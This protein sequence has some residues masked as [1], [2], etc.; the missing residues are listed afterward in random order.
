MNAQLPPIDPDIHD[1]LARR[2]GGRLPEGLLAD[3]HAAVAAVPMEAPRVR[4]DRRVWWRM[5]RFTAP[6]AALTLVAALAVGLVVVPALQTGPAASPAGYP[7]NRALTTAELAAVMAGPA[8]PVNTALTAT[9]TIQRKADACPMNSRPTVGVIEGMGSQVCVMGADVSAYLTTDKET[10]TF[11]FRYLG[12]GMLGLLGKVTPASASKVA[13]GAADTWPTTADTILVD[14]W[15]GSYDLPCPLMTFVPGDPLNPNGNCDYSWLAESAQFNTHPQS[16]KPGAT[17]AVAGVAVE[18][19]G[20]RI[21]DGIPASGPPVHGVFVVRHEGNKQCPVSIQESLGDAYCPTWLV[22]AKLANISVPKPAAT[23]TALTGYPADRPLTATEMAAL[24]AG[25]A[26]PSGTAIVASGT[27]QVR[28]DVCPMNRM[29]GIGLL[30]DMGSQVCVMDPGLAHSAYPSQMTGVFAYRY[31]L[32]GYLMFLG[33]VKPADSGLSFGVTDDWP[34]EGQTFVVQGWLGGE[35]LRCKSTPAPGIMEVLLKTP[36]DPCS[37][38]WLSADGTGP[39]YPSGPVQTGQGQGGALPSATPAPS[40]YASP[41]D[42]FN[43][44]GRARLVEADGA[45][46]LDNLPKGSTPIHGAFVVRS[47]V[48]PCPG[49]SPI[50][51]AGCGTWRVLAMVPDVVPASQPAP[52]PSPTAVTGNYPAGRPLTTAELGRLVEAGRLKVYDVVAVDASISSA[53]AGVCAAQ[54]T[55]D[56]PNAGFAPDLVG[57]VAGVDPPICVYGATDSPIQAGILALR[58]LGSRQLGYMGTVSIG[59]EGLAYRATDAW[60]DGFFLVDGWLDTNAGSCGAF[61][62]PGFGGPQPLNP[63]YNSMCHAA[64]SASEVPAGA[65][66]TAGL[67][68]PGPIDSNGFPLVPQYAIPAD[69]QRVDSAPYFTIP[70]S[71]NS[72]GSIHGVFLVHRTT[73]CADPTSSNCE[74]FQ[75]LAKLAD[76]TV[77]SPPVSG[78]TSAFHV[79]TTAEL[80]AVMAGP[81]L[82]SETTIVAQVTLASPAPGCTDN[83]DAGRIMGI[84]DQVCVTGSRLTLPKVT[85]VFAFR[86]AGPG[87]LAL[88]GQIEPASSTRLVH[89]GSDGWPW[90][91]AESH[92]FLVGGYLTGEAGGLTIAETLTGPTPT[93]SFQPLPVQVA[94]GVGIGSID[95]SQYGVFVVTA[96]WVSV[97]ASSAGPQGDGITYMVE[98]LVA[99]IPIPAAPDSPVATPSAS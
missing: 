40:L 10:G 61:T 1:Q 17:D 8:L 95:P 54:A 91:L 70:G 50:S 14:G 53:P 96:V 60:P 31:M 16:L 93:T 88:I 83:G 26:L 24:M 85:G 44:L 30:L 63:G 18:A 71:P 51:S 65:N 79:L 66:S 80:A 58:N 22:L 27:I 73:G 42:R 4:A 81:A 34:L 74:S 75:A 5:P 33:E 69:G 57:V 41:S 92:T 99:D 64:L 20:A 43:L 38:N 6:A 87:T 78:G 29:P 45:R 7:A 76:L 25:P 46:Q 55:I 82:A 48:A 49:V 36:D 67:G 47:I 68:T 35:N 28:N 12:P 3:I 15:L 77:T 23:P 98:G 97:P 52:T 90:G 32:P 11:A 94:A 59:P 39:V 2:S 19:Y 72:S 56:A 84:Q 89:Q 86:Y 62:L 21:Y 9:V 37:V 13:F